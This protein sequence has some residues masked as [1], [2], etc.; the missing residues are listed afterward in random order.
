MQAAGQIPISDKQQRVIRRGLLRVVRTTGALVIT[1]GLKGI[2]TS[3]FESG[4][5]SEM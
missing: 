3:R 2:S 4:L 5:V 1:D